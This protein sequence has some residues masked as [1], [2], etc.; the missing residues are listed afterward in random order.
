MRINRECLY[1]PEG[2]HLSLNMYYDCKSE[3]NNWLKGTTLNFS[4]KWF[5]S[6][7]TWAQG[8][9]DYKNHLVKVFLDTSF[10]IKF[11]DNED[12]LFQDIVHN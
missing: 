7:R 5:H 1:E 9:S 6:A 3:K 12:F 4:H 11:T 2:E 10:V 8:H